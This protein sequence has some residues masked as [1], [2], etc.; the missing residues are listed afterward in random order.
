MSPSTSRVHRISFLQPITNTFS[1]T[2]TSP[3]RHLERQWSF[4]TIPST[5]YGLSNACNTSGI[6][7]SRAGL[8]SNNFDVDVQ[9]FRLFS[10]FSTIFPATFF[11]HSL[12]VQFYDQCAKVVKKSFVV[13]LKTVRKTLRKGIC[14]QQIK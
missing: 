7:L 12:I 13:S 1:N 2:I 9:R 8:S 10:G 14:C 3:L 4:Q 6:S 5:N 11:L